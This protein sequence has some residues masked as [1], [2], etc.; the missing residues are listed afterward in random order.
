MRFVF[1]PW[2]S[3]RAE[4][5]ATK[6]RLF[7]DQVARLST[8]KLRSGMARPGSGRVYRR[9]GRIHRA[10]SPG[11]YPARETGRLAASIGSS[12]TSTSAEVGTR[13]SYAIYLRKGTRKMARRKMSDSAMKEALPMAR[14]ALRQFARW[15]FS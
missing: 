8:E 10:S 13:M 14:P 15:R 11:Q 5:D 1:Q 3:G 9:R 4:R 12:V 7:L 2:R 6:I